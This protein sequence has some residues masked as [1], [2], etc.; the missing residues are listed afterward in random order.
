[1]F[2][3]R[4]YL[5]R[6]LTQV[7]QFIFCLTFLAFLCRAVIPIGYMPDLSGGRDNGQ[8]A[9]TFCTV[10]GGTSSLMVD[11]D[12][13]SDSSSTDH[14]GNQDC[15]F[16]VVMTQALTPTQE[17]VALVSV[18]THHPVPLLHRNRAQPSLPAQ[19]P[20]LGSRAPPS[21]LG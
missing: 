8:F 18:V 9:I 21:N 5:R 10:G 7:W 13:P 12:S 20:P 19:G 3:V 15:P 4:R 6:N 17:A 14:I 1:M 2:D 11:L 16:G